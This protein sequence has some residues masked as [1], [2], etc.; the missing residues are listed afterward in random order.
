MTD[1]TP[2][3]RPPGRPRTGQTPVAERQRQSAERLRAAG[4]RRISFAATAQAVADLA[5]IRERE[6]LSTDTLAII[7]ALRAFAQRRKR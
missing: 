2:L 7:A 6:S 1:D 4:G 3:K 5:H